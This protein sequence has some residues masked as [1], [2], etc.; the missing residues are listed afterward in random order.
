MQVVYQYQRGQQFK[1]P[2]GRI[3]IQK[4]QIA[5][6]WA[7]CMN[8]QFI[9]R[10]SPPEPETQTTGLQ[11]D[12]ELESE[13]ERKKREIEV[14]RA[15]EEF[16][17]VG[18]GEAECVNCQYKYTP[19]QGDPDFPIAKGT[20]FE[21]LPDDWQCPGCGSPKNTFKLTRKVIAGFAAN[22]GYGLGTNAWTGDQKLLVIYGAL[23]FFFAL[24]ISGYFLD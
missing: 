12:P 3:Q 14:L 2:I 4:A 19:A 10:S 20:A 11:V 7:R 17:V 9:R 13:S 18:K 5:K 15:Q 6:A 23:L 16:M 1:A 21:D 22:Q 8:K 24:F